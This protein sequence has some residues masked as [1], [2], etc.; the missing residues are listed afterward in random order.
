MDDRFWSLGLADESQT[1]LLN[2]H[3]FRSWIWAARRAGNY[4]VAVTDT[5]ADG[6]LEFVVA[7]YAADNLIYQCR[8]SPGLFSFQK[9]SVVSFIVIVLWKYSLWLFYP[10]SG[11]PWLLP[12]SRIRFQFRARRV[13][14]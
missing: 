12:R 5:N 1:C 14:A 10:S 3:P 6:R 4:G 11:E 9:Y 7:G 8:P 13:P 2:R